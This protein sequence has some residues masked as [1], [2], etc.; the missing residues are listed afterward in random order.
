MFVVSIMVEMTAQFHNHKLSITVLL[1]LLVDTCSMHHMA[2]VTAHF[3]TI[4]MARYLLHLLADLCVYI[5]LS[6]V[7]KSFCWTDECQ[8]S[9]LANIVTD[10]MSELALS[11][12][13]Y[14]PIDIHYPVPELFP[15]ICEEQP[16]YCCGDAYATQQFIMFTPPLCIVPQHEHYKI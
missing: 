8:A 16:N 11:L 14:I 13:T 12:V 7:C 5:F 2:E 4:T 10:G 15:H 3:T 6:F 1:K 9:V